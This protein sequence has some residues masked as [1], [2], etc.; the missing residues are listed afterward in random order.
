MK[1]DRISIGVRVKERELEPGVNLLTNISIFLILLVHIDEYVGLSTRKLT[2]LPLHGF[3][4]PVFAVGAFV[5]LRDS[6]LLTPTQI[7]QPDYFLLTGFS[8][9]FPCSTCP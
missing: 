2:V 5:F 4:V 8:E 7:V 3:Y 1:R 9:S 6:S